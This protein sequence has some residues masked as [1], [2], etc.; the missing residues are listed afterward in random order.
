METPEQDKPKG[1][2]ELPVEILLQII[3]CWCPAWDLAFQSLPVA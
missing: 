1:L 3:L 2:L